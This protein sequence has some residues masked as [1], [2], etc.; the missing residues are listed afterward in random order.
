[1]YYITP[2]WL[3]KNG[4]NLELWDK[5]V[6][7]RVT[8]ESK[9]N[10]LVVM[11]TNPLAWHSVSEVMVDRLRCC[12]SNYYF[13][14]RSPTGVNYSNVTSFSARPEQPVRRAVAWV[15]GKVR[16]AVRWLAPS[17]LGK[18]DVFEGPAK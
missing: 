6:K 4:G 13:S 5:K 11:E 17:G 8:V 1:L 10:R 2:D 9:F 18:K 14:P 15:D 7:N 3:P 12:V 16:Q